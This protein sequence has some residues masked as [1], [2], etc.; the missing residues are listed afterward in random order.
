MDLRRNCCRRRARFWTDLPVGGRQPLTSY[1]DSLPF[2][3]ADPA[4]R[5]LR[6]FLASTYYRV[7]QL[8]PIL[9]QSGVSPAAVALDRPMFQV[10]HGVIEVARNRNRLRILLDNIS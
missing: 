7:D 10:W 8:V 2:N 5:E 9:Q 4:V 3:W 1:L 6:D